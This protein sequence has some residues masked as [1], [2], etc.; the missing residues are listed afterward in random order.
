LF[1]DDLS[2]KKGLGW[3]NIVCSIDPGAAVSLLELGILVR[4]QNGNGTDAIDRDTRL[5][6]T[7]SPSCI[8]LREWSLVR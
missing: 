1:S 8:L 4:L 6:H 7:V 3:V 2:F 5:V